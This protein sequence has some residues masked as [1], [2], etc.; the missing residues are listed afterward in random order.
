M[1]RVCSVQIKK[2]EN[3]SNRDFSSKINNQCAMMYEKENKQNSRHHS[4][5]MVTNTEGLDDKT[6]AFSGNVINVPSMD[7]EVYDVYEELSMNDELNISNENAKVVIT[8]PADVDGEFL[9]V[10]NTKSDVSTFEN[11]SKGLVQMQVVGSNLSDFRIYGDPSKFVDSIDCSNKTVIGCVF[12][13]IHSKAKSP[14]RIKTLGEQYRSLLKYL[15]LI[16]KTNKITL[17][18][19]VIGESFLGNFENYLLN[20]GLAPSTVSG[21]IGKLKHVMKWARRYGA[22]ISSSIDEYKTKGTDVKPKVALTM[23]DIYRI[24]LYDIDKL[25][26]RPQH[27]RTLKKVRDHFL[28][29]CF[30]GQRYSDSIRI[31]ENN[32]K[33]LLKDVFLTVQQKTGNKAR[34][35]FTKMFGEYPPIVK[36]ILGKYEYKAPWSG[37]LANYNR[38]LH[39]LCKHIGFNEEVKFEYKANN[40]KIVSKSYKKYELISSHCGRRTFITN[41]V[42]RNVNIQLIKEASGH[43][44]D[45]S[46]NKYV[47]WEDGE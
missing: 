33:G 38:Y 3:I 1:K 21:I 47:I 35:E 43:V 18:P 26:T 31:D 16:E 36:N 6:D 29:S 19:S 34:V 2:N 28:L 37:D 25:D 15:G 11:N 46:F 40:G 4:V 45:S 27:K 13:L 24:Y 5:G 42:K 23:N 20:T 22:Q 10:K 12:A 9:D 39:E 7:Q 14:E 17:M 41:A 8:E 44:S 30:V 32:F